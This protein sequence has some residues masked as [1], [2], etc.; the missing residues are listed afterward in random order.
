M[1]L[2]R[3]ENKR[4]IFFKMENSF[5]LVYWKEKRWYVGKLKE[6]PGIF[7]QGRTLKE[8]KENILD[9][10]RLVLEEDNDSL[11]RQVRAKM[12]E[13]QVVL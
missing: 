8:L 1:E 4:I 7:S 6:I 5:T 11:K 2:K 9:A 3:L 13:I 12:K 10:Y